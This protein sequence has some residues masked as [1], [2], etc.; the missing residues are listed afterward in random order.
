MSFSKKITED[1]RVKKYYEDYM[2]HPFIQGLKN[3]NLDREKFKNYLI[4]DSLYLKDYAKVYASAF[5]LADRVADLQFLHSCIGVVVSDETNMH[6][7]YL[8]DYGLDVYKVDNMEIKPEN[9]N[10][11]DYMLSFSKGGD[12]KEIFI[13]ALPCTLTYEYIGKILKKECKDNLENNYYAPWIEAYAGKEFEK[14]SVDS[15]HLLDR[16]CENI[17]E[18]EEEKL[19]KI[20]LKSCEHEMHFWDMSYK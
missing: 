11:L 10:Y 1:M 4:E 17:H 16:L 18:E 19:I 15:C 7:K 9:R 13:S 12:I 6:T 8:K 3:G 5:L 2:K 20:F 14:F